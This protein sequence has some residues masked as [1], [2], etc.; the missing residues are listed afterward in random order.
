MLATLAAVDADDDADVLAVGITRPSADANGAGGRAH[1]AHRRD[2]RC[3]RRCAR[4]ARRDRRSL[5]RGIR[6]MPLSSGR[7]IAEPMTVQPAVVRHAIL[8]YRRS[9]EEHFAEAGVVLPRDVE[10][11]TF[12]HSA[13]H[14][15]RRA[16]TCVH[17]RLIMMPWRC[18]AFVTEQS[19]Q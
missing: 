17:T 1:R 16:V 5:I 19:G 14:A 7:R 3:A 8:G 9:V 4:V 18:A 2:L 12:G 15:S 10:P 6:S 11:S 13:P